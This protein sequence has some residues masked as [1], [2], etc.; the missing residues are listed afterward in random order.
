M[1]NVCGRPSTLHSPRGRATADNYITIQD[2]DGGT[3]LPRPGPPRPSPISPPPVA[4]AVQPGVNTP[5]TTVTTASSRNTTQQPNANGPQPGASEVTQPTIA[6]VQP[7][8]VDSSEQNSA[9]RPDEG[10]VGCGPEMVAVAVPGTPAFAWQKGRQ[11]GQ[12]AFGT[13]YL[14]LVHATGQE[15]AVKQVPLPQN[16][17]NST[18]VADH[19]QSLEGEVAVLRSLRHENI[20]RYLGTERTSEHLNI[21]LEYVAGGP[22]SSKL[23][24]FGPL[25][26]ETIRVYTKQILRGLEYLHRQKVMHRDIKGANILVD[27]NGVVKLADFGASKKIEDL[28]TMGGGSR[29]IRGTP[30]WMAPEIIMQSGHG[31]A[32]D[33]WSL[34]CVVIEMATGRAPWYNFRDPMAVMFKVA[35]TKE[36]PPMPD[37][38]TPYAKDFLTLCFSRVPRE[39]PNATRL[40]AHPWLAGVQVPR[41]APTAALPLILPQAAMPQPHMG[42]QQQP[43]QAGPGRH[44]LP[45]IGPTLQQQLQAMPG[46]QLPVPPGLRSPPSPIK[47]ESDSRY[48]SPAAGNNAASTPTTART[49]LLNAAGAAGGLPS[50]VSPPPAPAA[51]SRPLVPPLP[52]DAMKN[53]LLPPHSTAHP[54][55][56]QRVPA[57]PPPGPAQP[58]AQADVIPPSQHRPHLQAQTAGVY[59]S[60]CMGV[61]MTISI[62]APDASAPAAG[63]GAAPAPDAMFLAPAP[64]PAPH[65]HVPSS[66]APGPQQGY[67]HPVPSYMGASTMTLNGFNPIEEPS[68][69]PHQQLGHQAFFQQLAAVAEH[70]APHSPLGSSGGATPA[71]L[72]SVPSGPSALPPRSATPSS[73]GRAGLDAQPSPAFGADTLGRAH[74]AALHA[75]AAD[76][77]AASAS[78]HSGAGTQHGAARGTGTGKPVVVPSRPA[79]AN[80]FAQGYEDADTHGEQDQPSPAPHGTGASSP[81]AKQAAQRPAAQTTRPR[82]SASRRALEE[83]GI[84]G[85]T[86]DPARAKKWRDELEAELEAERLRAAG[87]GVGQREAPA[88]LV[89]TGSMVRPSVADL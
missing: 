11:I 67:G 25:R 32:A 87:V 60:L 19:I 14:G 12:G 72:P 45:P 50:V 13:V 49:A 5:T 33:I 84:L 70:S 56:Q 86:L 2:K 73:D 53:G 74:V 29:S 57:V 41:P 68:W 71:P 80:I 79:L 30:N 9:V 82:V 78:Q 81:S 22:I 7:P 77:S 51:V 16:S 6:P 61:G 64:A 1:G 52:L 59:D 35:S 88:P 43:Q 15:I 4:P 37:T 44:G 47:E 42:Q 83:A 54:Q 55:Q 66:H 24:Q 34:G 62:P 39:R 38:L 28:A 85:G 10:M 20:V 63:Y 46:H 8:A 27:T 48:S 3:Y 36:L 23:A 89:A 26:E 76:A 17:T 18:K 21:F 65:T 31:R 40:L 58:P 75:Q 69:M